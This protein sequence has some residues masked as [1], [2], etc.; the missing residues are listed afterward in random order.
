VELVRCRGGE[1]A[2]WVMEACDAQGCLGVSAAVANR[3]A[4]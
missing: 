1:A 3:Q 4:A 2:E